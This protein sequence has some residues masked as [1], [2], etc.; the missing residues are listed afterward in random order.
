M[1]T[2]YEWAN[3]LKLEIINPCGWNDM[4]HYTKFKIS[5]EE[6]FNRCSNSV[7]VP[8]KNLSR[9]DAFLLKQAFIKGKNG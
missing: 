2:G 7:I 4:N 5:K 3:L 8:P 6:F 9:R 1:K